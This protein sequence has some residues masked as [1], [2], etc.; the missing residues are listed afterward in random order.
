MPPD[1]S[2][3]FDLQLDNT[4]REMDDLF[5]DMKTDLFFV[6]HKNNLQW[7]SSGGQSSGGQS[8]GGQRW[9]QQVD[10]LKIRS[11]LEAVE[12]TWSEFVI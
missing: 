9:E 3:D 5:D 12:F 4:V 1:S 7:Q 11:D 6:Y 2:S 8:S 10:L